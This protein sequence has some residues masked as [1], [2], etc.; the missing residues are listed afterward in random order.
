MTTETSKMLNRCIFIKSAAVAAAGTM[1][2]NREG[3]PVAHKTT[4][5]QAYTSPR[6]SVFN[7]AVMAC[8]ELMRQK[9]W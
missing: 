4:A 1:A 5:I 3:P 7:G 8:S 6:S 2:A 9:R